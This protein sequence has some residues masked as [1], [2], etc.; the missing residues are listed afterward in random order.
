MMYQCPCCRYLTLPNQPPGTFDICAVC[1][2][3]DDNVQFDDIDYDGGANPVSL[4]QA[5]Q[6]FA[7]FGAFSKEFVDNVRPPNDRERG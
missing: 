2:W 5:R 4:R 1:Y 3:E 7:Q 6:N